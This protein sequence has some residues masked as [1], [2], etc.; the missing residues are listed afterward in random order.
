MIVARVGLQAG[1]KRLSHAKAT[2]LPASAAGIRAE[3]LIGHECV[4]GSLP[5]AVCHEIL[6]LQTKQQ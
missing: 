6:K 4:P 2:T 5:S 1:W 3:V